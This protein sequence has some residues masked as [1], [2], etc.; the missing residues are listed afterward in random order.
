MP[1]VGVKDTVQGWT[2]RMTSHC[3]MPRTAMPPMPCVFPSAA[4]VV[5]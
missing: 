2:D 5:Q 4:G 3:V 1:A